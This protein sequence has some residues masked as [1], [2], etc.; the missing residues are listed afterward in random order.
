MAARVLDATAHLLGIRNGEFSR[1]ALSAPPGSDGLVLLPYFEKAAD[2]AHLRARGVV[3]G[4]T[5]ANATPTYRPRRRGG[6]AL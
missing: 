2:L 1:R 3:H 4:L 5:E 6:R